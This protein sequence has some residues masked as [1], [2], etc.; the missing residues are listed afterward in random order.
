MKQFNV[1]VYGLLIN[2]DR[3]ILVSDESRFGKQFTKFPGGGVE[4]GEGLHDALKREFLEEVDLE[5]QVHDL[6]YVNDFLQLSAFNPQHQL[7]SF[8]YFVSAEIM[9][10][11]LA[12][13]TTT[14]D[15]ETQRWIPLHDLSEKN[16]TFPL[17]KLVAEKLNKKSLVQRSLIF[18]KLK[19]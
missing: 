3:Q 1:R 6:F 13:P 10:T 4:F 7:L 18:C 14:G 8:Y 11:N 19:N 9:P 5:I 15:G 2:A 16:M 17:D 12:T